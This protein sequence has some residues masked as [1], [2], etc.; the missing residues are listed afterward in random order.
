MSTEITVLKN[1]GNDDRKLS[2]TQYYGGLTK[3][4]MIQL[5]QGFAA[6][7]FSN[8]PDEPGFIQLTMI[9]AYQV[10][11]ELTRWLQ[12]ISKQQAEQ[13]E[14]KIK[15]DTFL[16]NTIFSEAAECEKFIKDLELIS[17]PL[18]LLNMTASKYGAITT[19]YSAKVPV[20]DE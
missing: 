9:D 15:S 1:T 2:L 8:D 20:Q 3:G 12:S 10:I 18:R 19:T 4:M 13:L 6:A 7:P 11:G 17:I 14:Q 5:T 16:K